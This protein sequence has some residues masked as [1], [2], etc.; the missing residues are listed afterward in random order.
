MS[1]K[2][3]ISHIGNYKTNF[4]FTESKIYLTKYV[5]LINEY[6]LY[7]VESLVI[8]DDAYFLFLIKRGLKTITHCFKIILMYTKNINLTVFHCKKAFYYYIEF[9]E[10]ISTVSLSHSYLQLNST[11]ATLFVYKKTIYDINNAHRGTHVLTDKDSIFLSEI[12]NAVVLYN[13]TLLYILQ[14]EKINYSKKESIINFALKKSSAIIY[15]LYINNSANTIETKIT[16]SLFFFQ[17]LQTYKID[18]VG[19]CNICEIFI[20]KLRKYSME[21]LTNIR[22]SIQNKLYDPTCESKT[23]DMSRLRYVN[24][25]LSP[26]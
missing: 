22:H 12:S 7:I 25:L 23:Q 3:N 13:N 18:T 24:W 8:Q 2:L 11:D 9:V 21:D 6:M 14:K 17:I 19:Y 4:E 15:K 26:C 20:K 16:L 5:E 10:Q 1:D